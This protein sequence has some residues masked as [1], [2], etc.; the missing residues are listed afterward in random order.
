MEVFL[1]AAMN[2]TPAD[3][4][5]IAILVE[6]IGP[7]HIHLNTAVRPPAEEFAAPLSRE[8]LVSMVHLF[9]PTAEVVAEF[10][11]KQMEER[12]ANKETILSILQ[13]RPCTADQIAEAFGM[14][15]D[16]VLNSLG[17]LMR[18]A[19]IRADRRNTIIYYRAMNLK[20]KSHAQR[21]LSH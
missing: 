17:T 9:R 13:R 12:H 3:V 6:K 5:K 16:E 2:S 20:E 15:L 1:I 21:L 8:R 10:R 4:S 14:H 11:P 19:Q 18:N 7:D